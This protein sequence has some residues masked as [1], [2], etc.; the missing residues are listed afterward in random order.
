[1]GVGGCGRWQGVD[2]CGGRDAYAHVP[3]DGRGA[4][5][6]NPPDGREAAR[7]A[8]YARRMGGIA[9]RTPPKFALFYCGAIALWG[10]VLEFLLVVP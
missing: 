1:M 4:S 8:G 3:R 10:L 6:V 7:G 9:L 2:G 5:R